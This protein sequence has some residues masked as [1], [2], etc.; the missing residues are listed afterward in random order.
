MT[1]EGLIRKLRRE[2]G[3]KGIWLIGSVT[4][5]PK[6]SDIDIV[7][8]VYGLAPGFEDA[9][10]E[11]YQDVSVTHRGMQLPID[12]HLQSTSSPEGQILE[13][14][15]GP[16]PKYGRVFKPQRIYLKEQ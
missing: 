6:P 1:L 12:I 3:V 8:N 4:D 9:F 14:Y 2:E 13:Q 5:V 10:M 11:K 16:S 7:V 15:Q